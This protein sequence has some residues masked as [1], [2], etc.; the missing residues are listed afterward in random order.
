MGRLVGRIF[1]LDQH[2]IGVAVFVCFLAFGPVINGAGGQHY[3]RRYTSTDGL[4]QAVAQAIFQD[5]SGFI[6]IGTQAGLNRY[7]GI[8]FTVYSIQQGLENDWISAIAED[9]RGRLWLAT[10]GGVSCWD[11]TRFRNYSTS[12]G[13]ADNRV[14]SVIVDRNGDVWCAT[15]RGASRFD[16]RRWRTYETVD[17]LPAANVNALVVD[18]A[19]RVWAC[20]SRGIA[21]LEGQ[22]F[23]PFDAQGLGGKDIKALTE[24]SQH[25]LWVGSSDSVRMYEGSRLTRTYTKADGLASWPV[26]ALCVDRF[27]IT[28]AGTPQGLAAIDGERITFLESSNGLE[29]G[30][31]RS[32]FED[33]E[34]ILW[35]GV[36]G[37][38]YKLQGRAFT[39]FGSADGLG[40]SSVRPI[41]RD[42]RGLLW[43]GTTDGLSQFD[44]R[45][46]RNFTVADGL[47]DNTILSLLEDRRG[48]LW[49]GTRTGLNILDGGHFIKE[50]TL[51][52][53][54]RVVALAEDRPGVI[55]CAVQS[56]GLFQQ[57]AGRFE[58]IA[59]GGQTF[60][61]SRLLVDGQGTVWAS[62]DR[63]LSRWDGRGW[64]TF[65]TKDGL[66]DNQPYFLCKDRNGRIW[67]G[68][69][70]SRGLA[71]FDGTRFQ[72]FTSAQGLANDA[73][74]SLGVD[75][76]GNLWIGT[77]RGVDKFD[78][79]AFT[80]YGTEEGY[81]DN[82]SNAGGFFADH[83]GTLWFGTVGG[84]SHYNPRFD[85]THGVPPPAQLTELRL[86]SQKFSPDTSP[87]TRYSDND[88]AAHIVSLSFINE[89]RLNFQ[90]RL[91]GL[92]ESWSPLEGHEI[93]ITN[94]PP[95]QYTLEL[96]ARK[97]QG[98]W[99]N[100]SQFQFTI[101]EPFWQGWWFWLLALSTVLGT[102]Y[103]G[104][105]L[106]T[107]RVR[108]QARQLEHRVRERTKELAQKTEE[109]ESFI[110]T[111]SHDL[112]A[113]VI[114][115]QG[116]ASLLKLEIGDELNENAALYLERI[117]TNTIHMQ[118]LIMELLDLSRIGRVTEPR[119][120]V[121]MNELVGEVLDELQ[122][123][124]ELKGATVRVAGDLPTMSCERERFRRVWT[125][126]IANALY[127]SRPDTS[128]MI[129]I[130]TRSRR[131]GYQA[132][133]VKDN[134]IG[135]A[136]SHQEKVFDI[137]YRVE[138]K[139]NGSES[140][141]VGLAI[142]KR[143]MES[144]GGEVWVESRGQGAGSTFWI[145]LPE[146]TK[147][148]RGD[149]II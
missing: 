40:S 3:F 71:C 22:R 119:Q 136:K 74:Y 125:N 45:G 137:F 36:F 92:Q 73:V 98:P 111:I 38:L 35:V 120:P 15:A 109:M 56:V 25:H 33:R 8:S 75:R 50:T 132:F 146:D 58:P 63:G 106:Q 116:L 64:K 30:D 24:D 130:G 72:H 57:I 16:G 41:L 79:N 26:T 81:A 95:R 100:P 34:G 65:T 94:L 11:G 29:H 14:V 129:E 85:L 102:V 53:S 18:H 101:E 124:I 139:Y 19:D 123:Q 61:N 47:A 51:M 62:G 144:H 143:I 28:W 48:R 138:G 44:G 6:W 39:N 82:E 134:G 88:L 21:Y 55:W 10:A 96:Q 97:Y 69:H 121:K 91:R 12:E 84:L 103:G 131:R 105:R 43:V 37:G 135:I 68:Y 113:P 52:A 117:H 86:G 5:H 77:A 4:S 31:V 128:P 20:T 59:V 140:T 99:S 108:H 17:G 93:R 66:A 80:N 83:D 32:L 54:G 70:S 60:S 76:E 126:L 13:L 89:K 133:F 122:G 49:I 27:G 67:F 127:Y 104:H 110:Y 141:G 46:W 23:I 147:D 42:H 115:L 114:S 118:R 112:K 78:G 90:Y 145:A 2:W 149:M 87:V 9:S 7:D 107:A 142:V 148:L 1:N